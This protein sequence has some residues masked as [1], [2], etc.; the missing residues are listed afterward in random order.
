MDLNFLI[1]H[2]DI[3][4][5][6]NDTQRSLIKLCHKCNI[7]IKDDIECCYHDSLLNTVVLKHYSDRDTVFH[8]IGHF[9]YDN[10]V[11]YKE[12]VQLNKALLKDIEMLSLNDKFKYKRYHTISDPRGMIEHK[13]QGYYN[14]DFG[15]GCGDK[16]KWTLWLASNEM[17]A[18]LFATIFTWVRK[19]CKAP[20]FNKVFK[21]IIARLLKKV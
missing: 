7:K 20:E 15:Y 16:D 9:V 10:M 5:N 18:E 21:K 11:T 8:E 12:A 6:F 3:G 19:S 14:H 1:K 17:F 13:P 2:F 4:Y